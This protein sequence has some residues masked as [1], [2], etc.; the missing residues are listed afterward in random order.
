VS[1]LVQSLDALSV[2]ASAGDT[3]DAADFKAGRDL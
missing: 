3:G 2:A 1:V